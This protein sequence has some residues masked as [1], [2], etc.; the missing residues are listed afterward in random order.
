MSLELIDTGGRRGLGPV[1]GQALSTCHA[2]LLCYNAA[3]HYSLEEVSGVW[4]RDLARY[5]PEAGVLLVGL[6]ADR[7]PDSAVHSFAAFGRDGSGDDSSS[8]P[9]AAPSTATGSDDKADRWV[10][11]PSD[12]AT[13][14]ST[15]SLDTPS[16]GGTTHSRTSMSDSQWQSVGGGVQYRRLECSALGDAAAGGDAASAPASPP[17]RRSRMRK[18]GH[19]VP[20][21]RGAAVAANLRTAGHVQASA[22]TH[23]HLKLLFCA[24]AE[25]ALGH[26]KTPAP[27]ATTPVPEPQID[28]LPGQAS[29]LKAPVPKERSAA[30]LV[31]VPGQEPAAAAAPPRPGDLQEPVPSPPAA[32]AEGGKKRG[33]RKTLKHTA[34]RVFHMH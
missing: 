21:A 12:A 7:L 31:Q 22:A 32:P 16:V 23:L 2:V 29:L 20:Y 24:A 25:L 4:A 15:A 8:F 13:S 5:A 9:T 3:D 33:F 17:R 1:V 27:E 28:P 19:W 10:I 14:E 6:Q 26:A 34:K 11:R 18:P 30:R